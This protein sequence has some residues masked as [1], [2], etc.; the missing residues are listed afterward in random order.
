ML[1]RKT[2]HANI[3]LGLKLA[4]FSALL[5]VAT[6]IIGLVVSNV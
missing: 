6:I 1:D 3:T 5:F 2:A 4:L